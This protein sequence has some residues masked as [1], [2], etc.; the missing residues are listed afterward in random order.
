MSFLLGIEGPGLQTVYQV[1][2]FTDEGSTVRVKPVGLHRG[3]PVALLL[4]DFPR[5]L[6]QTE[7]REGVSHV[8]IWGQSIPGIGAA[9]AKVLRWNKPNVFVE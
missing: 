5:S 7:R 2:L 1:E 4:Q 3:K 8:K 6:E 9:S